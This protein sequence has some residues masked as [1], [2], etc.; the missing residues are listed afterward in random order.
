MRQRYKQR[1]TFRI[2]EVESELW[3][4]TEELF[5]MKDKMATNSTTHFVTRLQNLQLWCLSSSELNANVR[6]P[7][8][9]NCG[10]SAGIML[11]ECIT[12]S[13]AC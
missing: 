10:S 12:I 6:T 5:K 1:K 2:K 7:T 13:L 11:T 3:S 4:E 8:V 9:M